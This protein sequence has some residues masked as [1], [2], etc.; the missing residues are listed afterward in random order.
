[1][2]RKLPGGEAEVV[3]R[4]YYKLYDKQFSSIT[5]S[6]PQVW[7]EA[8]EYI[9]LEFDGETPALDSALITNGQYTPEQ[10]ELFWQ[11][12]RKSL[13]AMFVETRTGRIRSKVT[14]VARDDVTWSALSQ[15][16]AEVLAH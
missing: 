8:D 10:L 4:T 2:A 5:R 7:P 15:K 14:I 13:S 6:A 9:D 3:E 16:L 11:T 1:M 12:P